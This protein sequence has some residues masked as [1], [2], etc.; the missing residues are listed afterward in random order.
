MPNITGITI[1]DSLR[2]VLGYA[3]NLLKD[4]TPETFGRFATGVNGNPIDSNHPA[5]IYGHLSIYGHRILKD[6]GKPV[7]DLPPGFEENFAKGCV[8]RDDIDG[9]LPD[10]KTV[11]AYFF[12]IWNE[13]LDV[14][15]A[16]DDETFQQPNPLGGGF[17]ERFPTLGSVH[18]FYACGHNM[19]HLG[20][21][22]AWRRMMGLGA[23]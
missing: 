7:D 22:S 4:V 8:C 16:S 15:L 14:V 23:A 10:M 5:F 11:T 21:M 3:E 6:L 19:L 17:T 13:A 9:T 18:N 1:A 12:K 2:L 20:Q